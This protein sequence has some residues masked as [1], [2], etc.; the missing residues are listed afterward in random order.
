MRKPDRVA[1]AALVIVL[2]IGIAGA[3]LIAAIA[4]ELASITPEDVGAV[5]GKAVK[6]FNDAKQ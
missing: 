4:Y 6:G 5:A 3:L 2:A 1:Q